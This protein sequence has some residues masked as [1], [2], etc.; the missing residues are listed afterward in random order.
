MG[1]RRIAAIALLAVTLVGC[2]VL[3]PRPLPLARN[4]AEW[5]R[6]D[7]D[8][9]LQTAEA[10][11]EPDLMAVVR[12][13]QHLT[14]DSADGEVFAAVRSSVTK[15]CELERQ[16]ALMLTEVVASLYR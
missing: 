8:E 1:S 2:G 4:C 11:I 12:E 6:L 3:D 13:R 5:M 10:L 14:A 16:P 7:A 15:I 9:Q